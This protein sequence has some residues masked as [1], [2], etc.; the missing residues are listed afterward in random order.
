MKPGAL[1]ASASATRKC[2]SKHAE[3]A[4]RLEMES[5]LELRRLADF[6]RGDNHFASSV[7]TPYPAITLTV[8]LT[9]GLDAV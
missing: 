7:A 4:E 1:G 9:A 3:C 6:R 2:L 5:D 8:S